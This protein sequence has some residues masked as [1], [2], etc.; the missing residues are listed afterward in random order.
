MAGISRPFVCAPGM[1]R[2]PTFH[3][4]ERSNKEVEVKR[5]PRTGRKG[6]AN[7]A[8][9]LPEKECLEEA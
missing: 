2:P 1:A 7:K 3:H 9:A 8:R 5:P 4:E 6:Y